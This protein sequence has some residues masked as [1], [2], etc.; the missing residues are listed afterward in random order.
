MALIHIEGIEWSSNSRMAH[1]F[2]HL[3]K[4]KLEIETRHTELNSLLAN[5]CLDSLEGKLMM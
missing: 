3:A 4:L 2:E 1:N 5:P